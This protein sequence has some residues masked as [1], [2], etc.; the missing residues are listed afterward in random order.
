MRQEPPLKKGNFIMARE[1][2][3]AR[4]EGEAEKHRG[5]ATEKNSPGR[6]DECT[7]YNGKRKE[8]S[9]LLGQEIGKGEDLF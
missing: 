2:G 1:A 5:G 6:E 3:G 9:R 7:A 8:W 4:T